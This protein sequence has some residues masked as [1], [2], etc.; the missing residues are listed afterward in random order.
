IGQTMGLYDNPALAAYVDNIGTRIAAK[1]ERPKL[2][3]QFQVVDDPMVNAFAAGGGK[4]FLT[5]G[6][7]AHLTSE[8]QLA[9]VLGHEVGHVTGHHASRAASKTL[10]V[11]G[12]NELAKSLWKGWA[13]AA[14]VVNPATELLMLRYSRDHERE[15]DDLGYR[16]AI[17]NDYEVREAPGVFT[18]L[19]K[20][21][22]AKGRN[23][24]HAWLSSHPES[25]ARADKLAKRIA[26][27][28]PPLGITGKDEFLAITD[29]LIF[30]ADPRQ[31]FF[32]GG[33]FKH[34]RLKYQ[35]TP[36]AG[37]DA[38]ISERALI[39]FTKQGGGIKVGEA[40]DGATPAEALEKFLAQDGVTK[41]E[42][43]KLPLN[44][45]HVGA[46]FTRKNE[47]DQQEAGAIAFFTHQGVVMKAGFL[48]A[49]D[50]APAMEKAFLTSVATFAPLTEPAALAV[51][52]ARIKVVTVP[53]A[54]TLAE[55]A[56]KHPAVSVDRLALINQLE[57]EFLLAAG[58]RV[59]VVEGQLRD[60][61]I[62]PKS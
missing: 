3:W 28:R 38:A 23:P 35:I 9:T 30:E 56:K 61:H 40:F 32:E 12:A 16:Y 11:M 10:L 2:P 55:F 58:L 37:A 13:D 5:R 52:P 24:A 34:P 44:V 62:K 51:Q 36:P 19:K 8:A 42:D 25:G 7:L 33:V 60:D 1:S 53:E 48:T 14:D 45:A 15:A 21:A 47:K 22:D 17:E 27:H 39:T 50:Q 43:F 49:V 46:R 18:M 54:M 59:K 6:M 26:E 41:G 31:G 4:I 57:P 29:K 20:V